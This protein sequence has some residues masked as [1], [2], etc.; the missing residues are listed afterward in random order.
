[1]YDGSPCSISLWILAII[2]LPTF[3]QSDVLE[4]YVTIT[5]ICIYLFTNEVEHYLM[6]S[7]VI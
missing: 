6:Y 7:V 5:L 2:K 3:C 1:M 4:M